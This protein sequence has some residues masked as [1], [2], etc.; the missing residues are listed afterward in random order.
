M[1]KMEKLFLMLILLN[2]TFMT[3]S[4]I[5]GSFLWIGSFIAAVIGGFAFIMHEKKR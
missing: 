4:Y 3:G 2:L 5:N 1:D